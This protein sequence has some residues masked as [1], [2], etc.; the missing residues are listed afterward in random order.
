MVARL[1]CAAKAP[2]RCSRSSRT[3]IACSKTSGARRICRCRQRGRPAWPAPQCRRS[4]SARRTKRSRWWP[5]CP[6]WTKRIV[7]VSV[8]E[9]MLTIRGERKSERETEEKG[10]V[11]RERSFG[12]IERVVPLP[13]GLDLGLG[14]G[15]VQ[16]WRAHGHDRADCRSAGGGQTHRRATGVT[17]RCAPVSR[18]AAVSVT[19]LRTALMSPDTFGV[20]GVWPNPGRSRP[21]SLRRLYKEEADEWAK[22]VGGPAAQGARGGRRVPLSPRTLDAVVDALLLAGFDR[23][24]IDLMASQKTVVEKLGAST[25]PR[26]NWPTCRT[27][28]GGPSSRARTSLSLWRASPAS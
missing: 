24:D 5:S 3:S 14:Q 6:A 18:V 22:P 28:R 8:A 15:D 21:S 26:R 19:D 2:T 16:E 12:R 23:A 4:T 27:P 9:G 1:R 10:Y 25:S 7:E 11:L 20:R 17:P 13:A